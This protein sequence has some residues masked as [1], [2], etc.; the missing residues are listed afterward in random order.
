MNTFGN[1]F[2]LT[3]F[4]E[5]HG[6]AVG[7]VID[8]CPAGIVIDHTFIEHELQRRRD[9]DDN[10]PQ[11]LTT[12]HEADHVEWLSG[13]IDNTTLG[14]P[15]SFIVRNTD[16]RP[17]DYEPF[18]HLCRPGHADYT[19]TAKYGLRD[20][21][22]GGRA[23]GRE[24]VARVVAGAVAKQI[25]KV[26]GITFRSSHHDHEIHCIIEGVAA[27]MGNP[28]FDR[29]NARLSYAML[30]IPSAMAFAMGD[31]PDAFRL[32]Q[33]SFP[34]QW[35]H[36]GEGNTL[37]HT[38]HCGGIQGGISNGM[39][40]IFHIGFHLP[41]TLPV[42]MNCRDAEGNLHTVPPQGRHDSNHLS[43]LPVIVEAMAA[44][45]ILDMS[46]QQQ[47]PHQP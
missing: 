38:N 30:S 16:C 3:T 44:L 5:S 40:I 35:R 45:V 47:T 33:Q 2:R 18:R 11:G 43:R 24:T 26:K 4:G 25:L 46:L 17:E 28:I 9:G 10:T 1:Q 37:T 22:G 42:E 7:G 29:L 14:T 21:R 32:S 15:L 34:D 41:P 19:Y 31:T 13:L 12:R 39:P 23:S 6:P 27:G 8:G 36:L 20:H